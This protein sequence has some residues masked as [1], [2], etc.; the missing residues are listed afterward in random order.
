[1]MAQLRI[2]APQTMT[3]RALE[4]Y[5][6]TEGWWH[7]AEEVADSVAGRWG[8]AWQIAVTSIHCALS[9]WPAFVGHDRNFRSGVLEAIKLG[10]DTDTRG[11]V[12][13]AILGAL[14]GQEGIPE[15]W[16]NA[17]IRKDELIAADARL[18]R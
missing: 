4:L 14:V 16:R 18:D 10:G 6:K 5:F 12:T 9:N 8:N 2:A 13:G 15:E 3:T 1:M 7:S 17:L 11:A